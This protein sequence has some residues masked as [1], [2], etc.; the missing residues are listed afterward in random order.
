MTYVIGIDPSD[1]TNPGKSIPGP[2][3]TSRRHE[4]NAAMAEVS[5]AYKLLHGS[6]DPFSVPS[7]LRS[8]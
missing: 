1:T 7:G 6:P 5:R 4:L 2:D 3:V 8:S